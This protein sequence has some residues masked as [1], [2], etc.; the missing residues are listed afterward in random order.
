MT[1]PMVY[2]STRPSALNL[3]LHACG[4]FT[5][6]LPVA[7]L[8]SGLLPDL[9]LVPNPRAVIHTRL[10]S[11]GSTRKWWNSGLES[12]NALLKRTLRQPSG[13]APCPVGQ[14]PGR[15]TQSL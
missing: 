14:P 10:G 11:K 5:Y 1:Y 2:W 4:G 13:T 15:Q 9:V 6:F 12:G 3:R 7:V 8:N